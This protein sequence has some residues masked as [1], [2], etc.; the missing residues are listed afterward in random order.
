VRVPHTA[1]RYYGYCFRS[2]ATRH[3]GSGNKAC[4][5]RHSAGGL[6]CFNSVLFRCVSRGHALN[7]GVILSGPLPANLAVQKATNTIPIV[8][9][10]GADPV[11]FGLVK[12]LGHPGGNITGVANFAEALA[13]ANSCRAYHALQC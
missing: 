11:G 6:H 1:R 2:L 12:S 5:C 13:C 8:M 10:T 7:P 3:S 9:G 4:T